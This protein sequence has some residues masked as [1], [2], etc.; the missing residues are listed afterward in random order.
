MD[1]GALWCVIISLS[2]TL[3]T[4]VFIGFLTA[5]TQTAAEDPKEESEPEDK[6]MDRFNEQLRDRFG[7][8]GLYFASLCLTVVACGFGLFASAH[9]LSGV[10]PGHAYAVARFG[11]FVLYTML[12]CSFGVLIP[13]RIAQNASE[14]WI[15]KTRH[16]V[17]A[18]SL[19]FVPF[20]WLTR[21]LARCVVRIFRVNYDTPEDAV[22]E[23]GILTM[24]NEGA[25][26][27]VLEDTEAEMITNIFEYGD[28]EAADVMTHRGAI[29]FLS[30]D[31]TLAQALH[32]LATS[33]NTR[34][35]VCGADID[36]IVGILHMREA[37]E[38]METPENL[39]KKLCEI[40]G[41]LQK[42]VYVPETK[43][44]DDLLREMQKNKVHMIIVL[45][46]Y[47]QTSGLITMEDILEEIV[48]NIMD[49][50]DEDEE[51]ITKK[52]DG[53]FDIPGLTPFDEAAELLSIDRDEEAE[54][55]DTLNGY[56]LNRLDHIPSDHE[57]PTLEADG[58]R[59][60]AFDIHKG[61]IGRVHVTRLPEEEKSE[62]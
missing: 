29:R 51:T 6:G 48:G 34:Y 3:L 4:A 2:L 53:S 1:D 57:R 12:V 39:S 38:A 32:E 59:F 42:P 45:D 23:Q 35:P 58:W 15:K 21:T 43:N 40:D 16:I 62:D 25:E 20:A 50:Y 37:L 8:S 10:I 17:V 30:R 61:V 7:T 27:G 28:K 11:F 18:I 56:I 41:L 44:I 13:M 14:S 22:T 33:K 55:V 46:E 31:C 9:Y 24:V 49:E 54:E 52:E 5:V 47:G 19:L 26:Q 36:E 60:E